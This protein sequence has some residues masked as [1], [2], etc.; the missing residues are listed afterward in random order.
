MRS[1]VDILGLAQSGNMKA[2]REEAAQAVQ[3][4][5]GTSS[6]GLVANTYNHQELRILEAVQLPANVVYLIDWTTGFFL[7]NQQRFM[8]DYRHKPTVFF[9][10]PDSDLT[11]VMIGCLP[12]DLTIIGP[13]I[14]LKIRGGV[15]IYA[16][17]GEKTKPS[18][19]IVSLDQASVRG[20]LPILLIATEFPKDAPIRSYSNLEREIRILVPPPG[21][22]QAYLAQ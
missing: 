22:Q 12:N 10:Q 4:W 9:N 6:K 1:L 20:G 11:T 13:R 15:F 19:Q 14:D 16:E 21:R 2:A 7:K 5:D 8:G 3:V 18:M 17:S